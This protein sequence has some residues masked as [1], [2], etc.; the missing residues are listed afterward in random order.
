MFFTE[1]F[2]YFNCWIVLPFNLRFLHTFLKHIT[3]FRILVAHLVLCVGLLSACKS[4]NGPVEQD[5]ALYLFKP[6]KQYPYLLTAKD[7]T[8]TTIATNTVVLYIDDTTATGEEG[9]GEQGFYSL[10]LAGHWKADSL[11][12]PIPAEVTADEHTYTLAF[13]SIFITNF[14]AYTLPLEI[15]WVMEPKAQKNQL[16]SGLTNGN[17]HKGNSYSIRRSL[18]YVGDEDVRIGKTQFTKCRKMLAIDE[19]TIGKVKITYWVHPEKG[20]V[21]AIYTHPLGERTFALQE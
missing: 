20:F 13:P 1:S 18:Q 7:S 6:G 2:R 10:S 16:V 9:E 3:S 15:D 17:M 8:G 19:S 11:P 14:M 4:K 5:D 12:E 21:Q